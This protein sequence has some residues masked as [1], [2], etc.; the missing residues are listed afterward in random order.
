MSAPMSMAGKVVAH[1]FLSGRSMLP[2]SSEREE[3]RGWRT[4]RRWSVCLAGIK[5][6]SGLHQLTDLNLGYTK[7]A[8]DGL[9]ALTGL[10][11]LVCLNLDSCDITDG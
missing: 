8:S 2:H 5:Q 7:A 4:C 6:L 9:L 11:A 1:G 10:S 3:E